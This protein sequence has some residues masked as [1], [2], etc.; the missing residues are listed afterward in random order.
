[1][2]SAASVFLNLIFKLFFKY[3]DDFLVFWIDD[4]LIYSQTEGE[5]WKHIQLV[6]K[7]FCESGIKL[8]MSKC[9]FFQSEIELR[10]FWCPG[11]RSP[12]HTKSEIY[13][14]LSTGNLHLRS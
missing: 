10:I 4:L 5:D 11:K 14:R 2:Q 6:F 1:M 3:L 7:K 8:K 12:H 9:H 13:Y